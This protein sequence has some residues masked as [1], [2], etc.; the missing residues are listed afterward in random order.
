VAVEVPPG[1]DDVEEY[2]VSGIDPAQIR[3]AASHG[4]QA[5]GAQTWN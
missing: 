3:W 4:V 1:V 5:R 2:L